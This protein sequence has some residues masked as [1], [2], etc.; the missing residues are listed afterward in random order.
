[1]RA[2]RAGAG[3]VRGRPDKTV[4]CGL[5]REHAETLFAEA[6]QAA[7]MSVTNLGEACP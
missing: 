2:H 3:D 4:L 7:T 5:V 1:M 6:Q